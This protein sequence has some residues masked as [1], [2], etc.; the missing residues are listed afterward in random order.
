[1]GA[2]LSSLCDC[3]GREPAQPSLAGLAEHYHRIRQEMCDIESLLELRGK[4]TRCC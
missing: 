1:M 4:N 2:W 3:L